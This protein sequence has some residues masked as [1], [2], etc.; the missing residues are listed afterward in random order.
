MNED[1]L[2][3]FHLAPGEEVRQCAATSEAVYFV[4][5]CGR[6]WT[7][8]VKRRKPSSI[9]CRENKNQYYKYLDVGS[10]SLSLH[11]LVATAFIPNPEH[12]AQVNHK[13]GDKS[14]NRVSNLE[15]CT[16]SE[17]MKHAFKTGLS[18]QSLYS[19]YSDDQI[20]G[21]MT[22]C[23]MNGFSQSKAAAAWGVNENVIRATIHRIRQGDNNYFANLLSK[24]IIDKILYKDEDGKGFNGYVWK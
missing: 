19:K 9:R 17:N 23:V 21:V 20:R 11:R 16:Q 14:D 18:K 24:E 10:K 2:K 4:S 22:D 7:I 3:L 5:N 8:T 13:N 6:C 1:I 12:K 15:W